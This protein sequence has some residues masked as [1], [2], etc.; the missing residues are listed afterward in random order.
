MKHNIKISVAIVTY[1]CAKHVRV[2]LDS[3]ANQTYDNKEIVVVDG[4]STDET[5]DIVKEFAYI[6]HAFISEKDNGVYDAMNKALKLASGDFLIFLG[7]DDSFAHPNVLAEFVDKIDLL[8]NIYYG[9][10]YR[11]GRNDLYCGKFNSFKFAVKNISHQA[12]FYPKK[13]YKQ[14]SYSLDFKIFADY[15]YNIKLWKAAK[16]QYLPFLVSVYQQGGLS[17]VE[18][19]IPFELAKR[20]FVMDNLGVLPYYYSQFYKF[21]KQIVALFN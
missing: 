15:A 5:F 10:V 8:D 21:A 14:Y 6:P 18:Q 3:V 16:F 1:N 17:D 19:D 20:K 2:S 12:L 4:N 13:I 7:A 11:I 9:N